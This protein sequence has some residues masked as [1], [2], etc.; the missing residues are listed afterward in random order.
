MSCCFSDERCLQ[1][2]EAAAAAAP[3][4]TTEPKKPPAMPSRHGQSAVYRGANITSKDQQMKFRV[5]APAAIRRV[6]KGPLDVD[7][8]WKKTNKKEAW[9][10]CL[11]KIDDYLA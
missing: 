8:Q 7:R 6:E 5:F 3:A 10:S 9:E 11:R 1:D 2:S 4:C